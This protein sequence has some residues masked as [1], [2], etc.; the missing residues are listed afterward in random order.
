MVF[1][2]GIQTHDYE[3]KLRNILRMLGSGDK[4]RVLVKFKGR[5]MV[6]PELGLALL[7]RVISNTSATAI[8]QNPPKLDGKTY[9]CLLTKPN[10]P[11]L[12]RKPTPAPLLQ[13]T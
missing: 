4:V 3:V 12:D 10:K 8:V 11:I 1:H 13:S 9:S 7:Q 2:L 6:R 5:E